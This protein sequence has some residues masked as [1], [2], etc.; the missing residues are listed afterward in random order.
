MG[1]IGYI[2]DRACI[3]IDSIGRVCTRFALF[4]P[5]LLALFGVPSI[6]ILLFKGF[7]DTVAGIWVLSR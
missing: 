1:G 5:G 4:F 6:F 7:L 2:L 3:R